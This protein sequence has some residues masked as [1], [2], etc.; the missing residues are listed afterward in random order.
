[1]MLSRTMTS[2]LLIIVG[3]VG[4]RTL[5]AQDQ[6]GRTTEYEASA[7]WLGLT[8]GG[9]VQT[10][11]NR[12]DFRSDLGID[13]MQSQFGFWFSMKPWG[14]SGLFVEF[15][16]YRFDGELTTSRSFRFGGITYP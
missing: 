11:S 16:P 2:I 9:N 6:G 14:R 8:P 7:S 5:A 13:G 15:I 3:S 1:M 4:G 12:V 10:N